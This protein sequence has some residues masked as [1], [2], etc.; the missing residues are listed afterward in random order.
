MTR[1]D[2][3]VTPTRL[4]GLDEVEDHPRRR[5]GLAGPGRSLDREHRL[6]EPQPPGRAR[7]A[8]CRRRPGRARR[9]APRPSI[10]GGRRRMRSRAARNRPGSLDARA[11]RRGRRAA[12]AP[13][14]IGSVANGFV[15]ISATG[16]RLPA[17]RLRLIVPFDGI[18]LDDGRPRRVPARAVGVRRE[19]DVR[20]ALDD[21]R[22]LRGVEPVAVERGLVD[23]P[24]VGVE[25]AAP[26]ARIRP[27]RGR[28]SA[29]RR[30]GSGPTTGA[31]P[32]AGA[33]RAARRAASGPAGRASRSSRS[34]GT[35]LA[36]RILARPRLG[37]GL[38]DLRRRRPVLPARAGDARR[39]GYHSGCVSSASSRRPSSQSRSRRLEMQSSRL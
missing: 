20:L 14:R 33:S 21:L 12:P 13:P 22:V 3:A 9:P 15:G 17:L 39:P 25:R 26:R 38:G 16:W 2:W 18:E 31:S 34:S 6:V 19:R 36:Q 32:R 37:L 11:R 35:P 5:V 28:R 10:R 1:W 8:S 27:P 23:P 29:P 30:A 4:P 24:E 7:S